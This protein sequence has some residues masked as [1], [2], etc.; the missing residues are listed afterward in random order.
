[1]L[2]PRLLPEQSGRHE[3][4][5]L[6][7]GR[8]LISSSMARATRVFGT[9]SIIAVGASVWLYLE[10]R[11]LRSELAA[12]PA[13]VVETAPKVAARTAD[14]WIEP[15]RGTA[16]SKPSAA[17]PPSLPAD[18]QESRMERRARRQAEFAAMFGRIDGE[19]EDEYRA[20]IVPLIKAGLLIPRERVAEM[21]KEAEDKAHVTPEQSKKLDRA[22][23]KV[24]DDVLDYTNKAITDGQLSPYERNV[25]GWLEYAGGLG[26][27]LNDAQGQ[28]GKVLSPDQVKAMSDAGFEWGEYLGAQAPWEK[29]KP[30]PPP[31]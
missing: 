28:F 5:K 11:S 16:S 21:R 30:P 8:M 25:A 24:Y 27:L 20:R 14:P 1:M 4:R 13:P 10:N 31:K 15:S 19:T 18:K 6:R 7:S 29:L 2:S 23:D 22:I 17:T 9:I 26:G 12:R 3:C